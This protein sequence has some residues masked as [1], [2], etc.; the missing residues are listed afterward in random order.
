MTTPELPADAERFLKEV[1]RGLG[2][3]DQAQR[4]DVVDELRSHLRERVQQGKQNLLEGFEDPSLLAATFVSE[5]ALSS[6][7]AVGTPWAH[8]RAIAGSTRDSLLLLSALVSLVLVQ[9]V[10]FFV[11]LTAGL[12]LFA[13]GDYGLWVGPDSVFVGRSTDNTTEVLGAW[14]SPVLLVVGVLL[15]WSSARGLR[16]LARSRLAATKLRRW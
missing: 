12:K 3:L 14:G 11:V 13:P 4:D 16:A 15:F 8:A 1:R 6:A 2:A 10:A 7:L 9:I 5:H